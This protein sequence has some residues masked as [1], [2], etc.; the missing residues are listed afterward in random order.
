MVKCADCGFL[1]CRNVLTR[2]LEETE[3]EVRDEGGPVIAW[4]TEK[5][6]GRFEPPICF[7]KSRGYKAIPYQL[8]VDNSA[9][10]AEIQRER[11]CEL[12]IRWTQGSTPKEH[13][14]MM[15]REEQRKWQERQRRD[16]FKWRILELI[17]LVV[18]AGL[19]TLLGA[20][21]QRGSG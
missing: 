13:Q 4:N 3:Q 8:F 18:S 19:F 7:M 21:I 14:E 9:V 10:K 5:P 6:I 2:Q 20:W 11:S 17:V 1:A 12:F 16:D 15:D